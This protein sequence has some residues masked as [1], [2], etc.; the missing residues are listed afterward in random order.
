MVADSAD[1]RHYE[2]S[3][4]AELDRVVLTRGHEC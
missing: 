4:R 2:R 3:L 1:T